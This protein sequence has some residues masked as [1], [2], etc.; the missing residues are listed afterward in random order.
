MLNTV[1]TRTLYVV[2]YIEQCCEA[3]IV[4]FQLHL[5]PNFSSCH[6]LPFIAPAPAPATAIYWHLKLF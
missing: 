3:E 4:Y 1:F 6:L 2:R 5:C